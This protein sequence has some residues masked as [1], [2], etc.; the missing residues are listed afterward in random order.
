MPKK[1]LL[2]FLSHASE[3]KIKVRKLFKRLKEDGFDPWMDKDRLLP[4]QDWKF[5]IEQAL[6]KSDAI[7][8]CFSE[9]AVSKESFIQREFKRAMEY[10]EEKPEGE[11]FVIP[12]RLD[13][14]DVPQFI[15]DRQWVDFPTQ[16]KKLVLALTKRQKSLAIKNKHP[17]K[18]TG[19]G[20]E[21]R[22]A[23]SP[24][25]LSKAT[26][27][28]NKKKARCLKCVLIMRLVTLQS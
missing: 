28:I 20:Q 17:Q 14:C 19:A 24:D 3:D 9:N 10:Q 23:I 2:V 26:E 6:S 7:L 8:L 21:K 13:H 15:E 11:I 18:Q 27:E 5:E 4:G 22:M 12:V 25:L 1:K 16:Y